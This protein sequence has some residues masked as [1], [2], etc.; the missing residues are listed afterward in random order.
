MS[1]NLSNESLASSR[2]SSISSEDD[3]LL[4]LVTVP[5][6]HLPTFAKAAA[7]NLPHTTINTEAKPPSFCL[8]VANQEAKQEYPPISPHMAEVL[9]QTHPNINNTIHAVAFGLI[10][11]IHQC[12]L[13]TSQ[14]LDQS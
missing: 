12:T 10:T 4:G 2:C 11:T 7:T 13:A 1:I 8:T 6:E 9:L 3:N 5:E 14:K